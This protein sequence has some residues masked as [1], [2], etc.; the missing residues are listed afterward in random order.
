MIKLEKLKRL[1][2]WDYERADKIIENLK[3]IR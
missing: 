1:I 2:F 3:D